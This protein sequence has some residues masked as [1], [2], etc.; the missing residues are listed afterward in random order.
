MFKKKFLFKRQSNECERSSTRGWKRY[1]EKESNWEG[2]V[3]GLISGGG[4]GTMRR[5]GRTCLRGVS[6]YFPRTREGK[7][8]T[9]RYPRVNLDHWKLSSSLTMAPLAGLSRTLY[10]R[11]LS[12]F[13][14]LSLQ[15][16]PRRT[17][18]MLH[19]HLMITYSSTITVEKCKILNARAHLLPA[20]GSWARPR[21]CL[22]A[23]A[24]WGWS[25]TRKTISFMIWKR[26]AL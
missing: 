4:T 12:F 6:W 16:Q 18:A 15:M 26:Y 21:D 20:S 10:S 14:R 9:V 7:I 2:N 24:P 1:G 25:T 11:L 13:L 17:R 19:V 3:G 23:S 5:T 22:F 8:R